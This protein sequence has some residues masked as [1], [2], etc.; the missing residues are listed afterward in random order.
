MHHFLRQIA[1]NNA[2]ECDRRNILACAT[3]LDRALQAS[4][5]Q[6]RA[7]HI[8]IKQKKLFMKM[9]AKQESNQAIKQRNRLTFLPAASEKR[10]HRQPLEW[11]TYDDAENIYRKKKHFN[12]IKI[13]RYKFDKPFDTLNSYSWICESWFLAF[14]VFA[15][16]QRLAINETSYKLQF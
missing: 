7:T 14:A 11:T 16:E 2:R 3:K 12:K 10:L 6:N 1:C 5:M 9:R 4:K 13:T 8:T 15:S